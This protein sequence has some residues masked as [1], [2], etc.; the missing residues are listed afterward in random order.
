MPNMLICYNFAFQQL[1]V[2][3][4]RLRIHN[5]VSLPNLHTRF[6]RE[7]RFRCHSL[8]STW[9]F[10]FSVTTSSGAKTSLLLAPV[11]VTVINFFL[12]EGV[13]SPLPNTQRRGPVGFLFGFFLP[14]DGCQPLAKR[15]TSSWV[16]L[17]LD[18]LPPPG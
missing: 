1:P 9:E 2:D 5:S 12:R 6:W 11:S 13:I 3:I 17:L 7:R 18:G 4:F 14:L 8:G 15:W 16:F 10:V